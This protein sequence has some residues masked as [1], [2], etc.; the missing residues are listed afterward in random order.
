ML[1]SGI[2]DNNGVERSNVNKVEMEGNVQRHQVCDG[3]RFEL[4]VEPGA[5]ESVLRGVYVQVLSDIRAEVHGRGLGLEAEGGVGNGRTLVEHP[6]LTT[7]CRGVQHMQ[8]KQ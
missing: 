7:K 8:H 1:T 6:L 4:P 2:L 3:F 5:S